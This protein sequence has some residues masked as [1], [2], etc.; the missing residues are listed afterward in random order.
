MSH[1]D[2]LTAGPG[3]V[4]L[5]SLVSI[6]QRR[7]ILVLSLVT[8]AFVEATFLQVVSPLESVVPA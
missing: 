4:L 6:F 7:W 8:V 1:L 5:V 2:R 3:M